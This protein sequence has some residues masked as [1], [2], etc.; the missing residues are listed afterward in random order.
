MTFEERTFPRYLLWHPRDHVLA[1]D[2]DHTMEV[3]A[4]DWAWTGALLLGVVFVLW[5]AV[6]AWM[7]GFSWPIQFVTAGNA[8]AIML[9]ASLPAVRGRFGPGEYHERRRHRSTA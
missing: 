6:Q 7:I 8:V 5:L 3:A 2:A 9:P 4:L 1:T